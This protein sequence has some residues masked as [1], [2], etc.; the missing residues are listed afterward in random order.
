MIFFIFLDASYDPLFD[1][2]WLDAKKLCYL[3]QITKIFCF[4]HRNFQFAILLF[5]HK[6]TYWCTR[7]KKNYSYQIIRKIEMIL[8][9]QFNFTKIMRI[10]NRKS[11]KNAFIMQFFMILP[12][13][14]QL[15]YCIPDFILICK[16]KT[17]LACNPAFEK[18]F[19]IGIFS[20]HAA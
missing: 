16:T 12:G 8:N 10:V 14:A 13:H 17:G 6:T 4:K 11:D 2:D 15:L 20:L 19:W 3:P 18:F 5:S 1:S 9:W 7:I